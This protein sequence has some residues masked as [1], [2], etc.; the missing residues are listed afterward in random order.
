MTTRSKLS[1]SRLLES[2][3]KTVAESN[4][5]P[6]Q[7]LAEAAARRRRTEVDEQLRNALS[8]RDEARSQVSALSLRLHASTKRVAELK[9]ELSKVKEEHALNRVQWKSNFER[10][11]KRFD[12]LKKAVQSFP[13][14]EKI[15]KKFSTTPDQVKADTSVTTRSKSVDRSLYTFSHFIYLVSHLCRHL[16]CRIT[17]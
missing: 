10:A 17:V 1:L 9:D 3:D 2:L 6:L 7:S 12:S 16:A 5:L 13:D 14:S 11:N 15:L 4:T 8:A